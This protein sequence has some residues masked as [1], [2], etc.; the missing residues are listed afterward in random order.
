MLAFAILGGETNF[1]NISP[2]VGSAFALGLVWGALG[3]LIGA[4]TGSPG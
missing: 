1:T 4:A 2:S 3:G